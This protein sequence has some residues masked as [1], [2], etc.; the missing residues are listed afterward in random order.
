VEPDSSLGWRF[1]V[2]RV[3][4]S[5]T[6]QLLQGTIAPLRAAPLRL[7]GM[8]LLLWVPIE[9]LIGLEDLGLF[10]KEAV[11]AVAFTGYTCALD[12]AS[13]AQPPDFSHL[14]VIL[15]FGRD[16]LILLVISG[17]VPIL[18]GMLLLYGVWGQE[19]T[20]G[21]L[22][23]LSRTAGHPSPAMALDLRAADYI[24]SMP[25]TF[26]APVWALY[27]WSG[28]RS[29]AANLLACLVNWRWVL[30]TTAASA[31]ADTLFDWLS[32]RGEQLALLALLGVI[33]LQMLSLAW[34]L[35]LAQ[36]SF[37]AR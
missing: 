29:M 9:A 10:L 19:A 1:A 34:I 20:A 31:L 27:H 15:R 32:E 23:D 18:I 35:A 22:R 24:A 5:E 33:A 16:K 8:F 21:F 4:F 11:A 28:S 26:V 25:F 30:V 37:P 2:R 12:A 17:V 14:G 6:R 13:R 36:R 7:I 3:S